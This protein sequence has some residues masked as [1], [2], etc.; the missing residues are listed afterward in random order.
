MLYFYIKKKFKIG[1]FMENNKNALIVIDV[2]KAFDNQ[3]WGER[4]NSTFGA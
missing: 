4:N 2:Q 3:K 1:D